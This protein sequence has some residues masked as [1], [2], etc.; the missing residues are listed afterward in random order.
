[1]A[2]EEELKARI[3][4]LAIRTIDEAEDMLHEGTPQMKLQIVKHFGGHMMRALGRDE[5][6]V[7]SDLR[8][9]F[10]KLIEE[11]KTPRGHLRAVG[12]PT[13]D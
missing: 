4:D 5:E 2:D 8:K 10:M 1:M 12:G 7:L 3:R 6:D 9:D 13:P 11:Q